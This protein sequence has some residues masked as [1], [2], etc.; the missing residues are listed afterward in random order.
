MADAHFILLPQENYYQWVGAVADYLAKFGASLTSDPQTPGAFTGGEVTV[1]IAV[2]P[3]G[4]PAQGDDVVEWLKAKYPKLRLDPIRV[5]S[6]DELKSA[7]AKR[8]STSQRFAPVG[9]RAPRSPVKLAVGLHDIEGGQWLRQRGL[10]GV[11]LGLATVQDH[12]TE[13]DYTELANAGVDVLLR[14]N[15]GFADGSGTLPPPER[16]AKFEQAT[17]ETLNRVK[18]IRAAQYGNEMNN[19]SEHPGWDP[20]AGRPGPNYFELTPDYYVASYNRVWQGIRRDVKLGPGALD[21]YYGP[22]SDNREWWRAILKGIAGADAFYLHP[23][24]QSNDAA[25][26]RSTEKFTNDPLTWQYRHFRA[27]E[28]ALAEVPDRFADLPVYITEANPQ[29]AAPDRPG[30]RP[31][32]TAWVDECVRYLEEWNADPDRQPV[33]GV[34]FYRWDFDPW[35]LR[36]KP[37]LLDRVAEIARR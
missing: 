15:Y 36:D 24:T 25:E 1:T 9:R 11:C 37:A 29:F 26:I 21:P 2:A 27:L 13:I 33:T 14:I 20:G 28:T 31:D 32:N 18:G 34:I 4:Y 5:K 30:W 22:G 16:L 12:F 19:R 23:K 3:G 10:K 6:P 7:L 35:V 17:I 8:I